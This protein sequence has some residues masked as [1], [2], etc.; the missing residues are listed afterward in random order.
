[1]ATT[2]DLW[3]AEETFERVRLDFLGRVKK[4]HTE[5]LR[6]YQTIDEL[7]SAMHDIQQKQAKS[8]TLVALRRI[9]PYLQGLQQY[10]SVLDTF[11]QVKPEVMGLVWGG[12]RLILQLA[13]SLVAAFKKLVEVLAEIGQVL[14]RFQK[15]MESGIFDRNDQVK[16]MMVVFYGD[17]LDLHLHM[18]RLFQHK[19]LNVVIESL[20]PS[21]RTKLGTILT[22]IQDHRRVMD[23]NVTLE[24]V[25][26]AHYH[27]NSAE[28]RHVLETLSSSHCFSKL[29]GALGIAAKDSG[30]WIYD[31]PCFK[32]WRGDSHANEKQ[33]LLWVQGIPGAGKVLE[34]LSV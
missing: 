8:K 23:D 32:I 30:N 15:Y 19:T 34:F 13:N 5:E 3:L 14:P 29:N 27:L 21:F 9:E 24:D 20:W 1:M 10:N 31:E 7:Y 17:I 12:L 33:R 16:G 18:L 28:I 4:E 11:C 26:K 2:G 22:S 25:I 6:K